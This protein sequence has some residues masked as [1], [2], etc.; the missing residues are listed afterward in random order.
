MKK[1]LTLRLKRKTHD[2]SNINCFIECLVKLFSKI[3]VIQFVE[4][5]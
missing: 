2:Y 5:I 4:E 1:N 3:Y